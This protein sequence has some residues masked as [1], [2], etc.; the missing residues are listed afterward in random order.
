MLRSR[1]DIGA[2]DKTVGLLWVTTAAAVM[3]LLVDALP[4]VGVV[5]KWDVPRFSPPPPLLLVVL[6]DR[7]ARLTVDVGCGGAAVAEQLL[8]VGGGGGD[9]VQCD[10]R[11]MLEVARGEELREFSSSR[12]FE[13]D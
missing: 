3:L 2:D 1:S 13:S 4:I 9:G 10:D 7:L 8:Y 5:A 12:T 6:N 11:R